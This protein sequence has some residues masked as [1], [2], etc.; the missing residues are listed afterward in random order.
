M[1]MKGSIN[2]SFS[3]SSASSVS[4][5]PSFYRFSPKRYIRWYYTY[6]RVTPCNKLRIYRQHGYRYIITDLKLQKNPLGRSDG[7][8]RDNF[9]GN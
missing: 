2:C 3:L 9:K 6:M 8:I 5:P 4:M 1:M 7:F